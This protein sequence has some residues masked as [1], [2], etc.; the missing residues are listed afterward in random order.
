MCMP[1]DSGAGSTD[2]MRSAV[3]RFAYNGFADEQR[4][5]ARAL[6]EAKRLKEEAARRRAEERAKLPNDD[7]MRT[8]KKWESMQSTKLFQ[9][10]NDGKI[11]TLRHL[12][13][14][15]KADF[16]SLRSA[17]KSCLHAAIY[18]LQAVIVWYLMKAGADPEWRTGPPSFQTCFDYLESMAARDELHEDYESWRIVK[19]VL[20]RM[21]IHKA[22]QRG[23]NDYI[24]FLLRDLKNAV[25][26]PNRN[27][28]TALHF[29]VR[30][31]NVPLVKILLKYKARMD[32]RSK[33]GRIPLDLNNP[34]TEEGKEIDELLADTYGL[35]RVLKKQSAGI[36]GNSMFQ[37]HEAKH[38]N[39]GIQDKDGSLE[40]MEELDYTVKHL[41]SAK[42][43]E[44][45]LAMKACD[46]E[47]DERESLED[48][49]RRLRTHYWDAFDRKRARFKVVQEEKRVKA[50][51]DEKEAERVA[52]EPM[53]R[54]LLKQAQRR[55]DG[56]DITEER[57]QAGIAKAASGGDFRKVRELLLATNKE[58]PMNLVT[59]QQQPRRR[60]GG[61]GAG[62][63]VSAKQQQAMVAVKQPRRGQSQ[64]T[65]ARARERA[66]ELART[67]ERERLG[68]HST[69]RSYSV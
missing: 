4:Q 54:A 21:S 9:A 56:W 65:F 57:R 63:S 51:A 8:I 3:A 61:A 22:A 16:H 50:E 11:N 67:R 43:P 66:Q 12:I 47:Y 5:K 38:T 31:A 7:S 46:L 30:S 68:P 23:M 36:Y 6:A 40:V 1:G 42:L 53:R 15:E 69:P 55:R 2:E 33:D 13:E 48:I 28:M 35:R 52:N 58:P 37:G 14:V 24:E 17:G 20:N 45:L 10:V 44:L 34:R 39:F 19:A 29:A 49:V 62:A 26:E 64:A 59:S 18:N 32:A 41:L 27:G 60:E 25:D